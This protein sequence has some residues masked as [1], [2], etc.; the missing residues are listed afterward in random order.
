MEDKLDILKYEDLPVVM[1]KLDSTAMEK[2]KEMLMLHDEGNVIYICHAKH[3]FDFLIEDQDTKRINAVDWDS[4]NVSKMKSYRDY[5]EYSMM[6]Q[7]F[8]KKDNQYTYLYNRAR[9][10]MNKYRESDSQMQYPLAIIEEKYY[11]ECVARGIISCSQDGF[12]LAFSPKIIRKWPNENVWQ[13]GLR[14]GDNL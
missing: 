5:G 2:M 12:H 10:F 7:M 4:V 3:A 14:M 9:H 13:K 1:G 11:G 8:N 6:K